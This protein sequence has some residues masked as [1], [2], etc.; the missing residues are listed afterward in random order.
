[1]VA[2]LE[3]SDVEG[4]LAATRDYYNRVDQ[5]LMKALGGLVGSTPPAKP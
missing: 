2:T 1:V 5:M 4:A 3:R